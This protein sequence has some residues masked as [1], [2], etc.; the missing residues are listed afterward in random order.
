MK[1]GGT[2]GHSDLLE[3]NI[4]AHTDN[5]RQLRL[6]GT[7]TKLDHHQKKICNIDKVSAVIEREDEG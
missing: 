2:V 5:V 3:K 7:E 4:C 1:L 6:H